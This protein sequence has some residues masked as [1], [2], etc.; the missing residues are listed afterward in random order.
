[1]ENI[2]NRALISRLFKSAEDHVA[3]ANLDENN[4]EHSY[5]TVQE[6]TVPEKMVYI[7]VKLNQAV[8]SGGFSNF[9]ES[10]LGIFAPE[11][12]HVFNEIKANESARIV[13]DSLDIVNQIGLLD[14][15]FKSFVFNI[16]LS[17]H[18]RMQLYTLDIRYD[19]LQDAENLEDLLGDYLQELI[20]L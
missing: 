13:V 14:H 10:S 6:L 8:T 2:S 15:A 5:S 9:Y 1:M 17:E 16:Q 18:Q 12:I 20:K 11:I 4:W 19:Q 7:I 3:M